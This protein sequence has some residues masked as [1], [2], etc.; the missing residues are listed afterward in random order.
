MSSVSAVL[1]DPWFQWRALYL[2]PFEVLSA[3][4]AVFLLTIIDHAGRKV[5]APEQKN[6]ML[7]RTLKIL[8]LLVI[9]I[10]SFNYGLKTDAILP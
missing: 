3:A 10:D 9:L 7:I 2:I 5:P 6:R 8:L 1:L 4:G